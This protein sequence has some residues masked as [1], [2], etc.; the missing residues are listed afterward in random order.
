MHLEH[1][2]RFIDSSQEVSKT[3]AE[4]PSP[5]PLRPNIRLS[6]APSKHLAEALGKENWKSEVQEYQECSISYIRATILTV[7]PFVTKVQILFF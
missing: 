6:N 4:L 2:P 7:N 3:V 1:C 5:H